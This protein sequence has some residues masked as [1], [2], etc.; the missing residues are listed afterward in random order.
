MRKSKKNYAIIALVVILL[1]LA[2]GY[3]AF[4]AN[5]TI[6]GTATGTGTWEVKFVSAKM[7][8]ADHGTVSFTDDAVTVNAELAFPGD[9]C[10]VTVEIK[11]NGSMPAKLTGLE[12]KAK[13]GETDFTSSDITVGYPDD[14]DVG[15]EVIA[16]GETCP[17]TISIK[18]N[19]NSVA[20]NVSAEFKVLFTYEQDTTSVNVAPSHGA[21][22]K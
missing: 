13:D 11:N 14:I 9:G 5:L 2:I 18:W 10:T 19:D 1:C 17:I 15:S 4:T 3:A 12:L 21:H 22:T 16:A 20:K 7:S 6:N 8:D